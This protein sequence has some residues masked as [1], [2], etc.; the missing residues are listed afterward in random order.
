V[1]VGFAAEHGEGAVDY[2]RGKLERKRLDAVVV[3]DIA[4]EDIGFDATE[5]EVWILTGAGDVHVPR[6][7]KH[8]VARAILDVALRLRS[9]S[10]VRV[11][12]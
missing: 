3:N 1:L 5:N 9:S 2:G 8:E 7:S 11:R 4:R 10:T 12:A 6:T